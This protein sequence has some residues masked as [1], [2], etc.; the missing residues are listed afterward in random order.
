MLA[1]G[2]GTMLQALGRWGIGS[3]YLVPNLVGPSFLSVSIQAAWL[4][5][6]LLMHGMTIVSGY[7][8]ALFSRVVH[9]LR[10]LFP[11]EI[12]GLVVLMVGVALIPLGPSRF[13]GITYWHFFDADS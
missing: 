10:F 7:F 13:L 1:A 3:G 6:L 9:R 2:I 11:S 4:G 12:T 8:E 5:G